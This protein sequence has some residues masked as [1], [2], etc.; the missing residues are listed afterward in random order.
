[1]NA[2]PTNLRRQQQLQTQ[3]SWNQNAIEQ[4]EKELDEQ[5]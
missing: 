4:I 2:C 5:R 3:A 1:M